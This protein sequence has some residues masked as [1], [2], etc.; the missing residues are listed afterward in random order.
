MQWNSGSLPAPHIQKLLELLLAAR[1]ALGITNDTEEDEKD[2]CTIWL[3][4]DQGYPF[5]PAQIKS[6][7]Y[8]ELQVMLPLFYSKLVHVIVVQLHQQ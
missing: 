8:I 1:S 5:E 6:S 7:S 2:V 4:L 3:L